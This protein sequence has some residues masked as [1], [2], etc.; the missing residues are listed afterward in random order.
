MFALAWAWDPL[1]SFEDSLIVKVANLRACN[2]TLF[3]NAP[4]LHRLPT[5]EL[6]AYLQRCWNHGGSMMYATTSLYAVC[7]MHA[8]RIFPREQFLFLRYEDLMRMDAPALLRLLGRFVGLRVDDELLTAATERG[9]CQPRGRAKKESTYHRLSASEK[10]LF[11]AS[12]AR[13]KSAGL[14]RQL[15]DFFG[16]Y[17]ELLAELVH[18]DFRW[19]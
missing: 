8:L 18:P 15:G 5:A 3:R 13:A 10:V 2:E 12:K 4:L 7:I 16:P 11:N 14:R 9:T 1:E 6:T 17:N 19:A